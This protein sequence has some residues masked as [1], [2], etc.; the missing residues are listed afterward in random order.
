MP[1]GAHKTAVAME[2]FGRSGARLIPILNRGRAGVGALRAEAHDLGVVMDK[3]AAEQSEEF[4]MALERGE[5][6]VIGIRNA[7]GIKLLPGLTALSDKFT[8]YLKVNGKFISMKI[9]SVFETMSKI[10]KVVW[11]ALGHIWTFTDHIVQAFGGWETVIKA[12]VVGFGIFLTGSLLIAM[13]N[14]AIGI[15]TVVAGLGEL[16]ALAIAAQVSIFAVP[17]AIGAAIAVVLLAIEDVMTYFQGGKSVTGVMIEQFGHA[18]KWI[19]DKMNELATYL[20]GKMTAWANSL[21]ESLMHALQPIKNIMDR[22]S[23]FGNKVSSSVGDMATSASQWIQGIGGSPSK[24][25]SEGVGVTPGTSPLLNSRSSKVMSTHVVAPM[26]LNVGDHASPM[27]VGRAAKSG[28][29]D[30]LS[31]VLRGAN[32]SFDGGDGN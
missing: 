6:A 8:E 5:A 26:T 13:G 17:L 9:T 21:N 25:V 18:F 14:L 3:E 16:S 23:G 10:L 30:G 27:E 4:N 28:M 2:L 29:I 20:A 19:A 15:G 11:D 22:V 1:D 31:D 32:E 7:I 12:V 24:T